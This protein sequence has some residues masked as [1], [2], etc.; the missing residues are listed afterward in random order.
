MSAISRDL[1]RAEIRRRL[2]WVGFLSPL[3]D[4]ELDALLTRAKF[5]R[6]GRGQVM[7]V[8]AEEH[9]DWMHVVLEGHIQVYETSKR[10]ERELTISVLGGGS[11][12]NG[13]GVVKR[14]TRDLNLRALE[15][16]LVCRLLR[17]DLQ[18]V[19]RR[20]PEVGI[21][22]AENLATMSMLME[23]RWA[24]MVEKE[25]TERLAGLIYMLGEMYGIVT[26]DGPMLPTRYTHSQLAS[27]IG[28]N[29]EAVTR[30]FAKLRRAGAIE[31][32]SRRVHIKDF[33]ALR[34]AAGE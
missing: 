7:V 14:W 22:L 12:V 34:R 13:T 23:D 26:N 11:T 5:V 17:G 21:A 20:N 32:K 19:I 3:P 1:P 4:E 15:P 9:G 28:S 18:D 6:L 25:I 24:D 27:M 2:S 29:R 16:S 10:S 30:A 8:G 31:V 33:D